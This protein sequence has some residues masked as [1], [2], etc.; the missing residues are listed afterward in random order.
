MSSEREITIH[1]ARRHKNFTVISNTII[2]HALLSAR[3]RLALIYLLSKPDDWTLQ[4]SDLR[5]VLGVDGKPLGRDSAYALVNELAQQGYLVRRQSINRDGRFEGISY[6]VYDEPVQNETEESPG[7]IG[8]GQTS[9]PTPDR[10]ATSTLGA[11][12]GAKI[13]PIRPSEFLRSL[14]NS[15]PSPETQEPAIRPHPAFPK[16]EKQDLTKNRISPKNSP[17]SPPRNALA[18]HG[19]HRPKFELLWR[20]WPEKSRPQSARAAER[21][22]LALAQHEQ[23]LAV[24]FASAHRAVCGRNSKTALMIPYLRGRLFLEFLGAPEIDREGNFRIEPH[25]EE[26]PAWLKHFSQR[27]GAHRAQSL[28]ALGF[29]LTPSRWP[30]NETAEVRLDPRGDDGALRLQISNLSDI[31]HNCEGIQAIDLS[32]QNESGG[33]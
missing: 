6:S 9:L 4:I 17:H 18:G 31:T 11:L 28:V 13:S 27:F 20:S 25:R 30:P 22:F 21:H 16:S 24:E 23:D 15:R 5:R 19:D 7:G 14:H 3:A 12:R 29:M 26:W 33:V 8:A 32:K 2:E 1:R 10:C